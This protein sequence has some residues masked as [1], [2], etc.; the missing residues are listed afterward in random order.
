MTSTSMLKKAKK[1]LSIAE[2]D[3]RHE[4]DLQYRRER[5]AKLLKEKPPGVKFYSITAR[6][7][8]DWYRLNEI[9]SIEVME[10]RKAIV[11]T[12]GMIGAAASHFGSFVITGIH[13]GGRV[14]EFEYVY[15][16]LDDP[17]KTQLYC[18][19]F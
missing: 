2:Q 15:E 8:E 9:P 17:I 18:P 6:N 5:T 10:K 16:H 7:D 1:Q 3:E 12:G 11:W 19:L 4:R 13:H 14:I